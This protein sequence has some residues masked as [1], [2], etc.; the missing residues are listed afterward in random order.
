VAIHPV[1][2]AVEPAFDG[3]NRLTTAFLRDEY[4]PFSID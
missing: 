2:I 1:Q 4:P 3:R